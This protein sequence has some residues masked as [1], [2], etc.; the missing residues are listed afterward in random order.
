MGRIIL[1]LIIL[2]VLLYNG[3][4]LVQAAQYPDGF[5]LKRASAEQ[6]T[7]VYTEATFQVALV[8][9]AILADMLF[10]LILQFM[11]V[12]WREMRRKKKKPATS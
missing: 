7:Q 11:D 5:K 8:A 6:V 1:G 4:L 10:L 3:Y 9:A 12:G 2:A